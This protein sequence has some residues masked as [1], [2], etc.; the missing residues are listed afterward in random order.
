[1]ASHAAWSVH[2][3]PAFGYGY[4]VKSTV[5]LRRGSARKT[6]Q[7]PAKLIFHK[8][9]FVPILLPVSA[10]LSIFDFSPTLRAAVATPE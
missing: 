9:R 5:R 6:P 4:I 7:V 2:R 1:M 8:L 10:W 3:I